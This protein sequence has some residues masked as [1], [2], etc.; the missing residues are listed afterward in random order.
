MSKTINEIGNRYGRLVVQQRAKNNSQGRAQWECLCDCGNIVYV[1]GVLLRNGTTKSC[2]CLQKERT[3]LACSSNLIG[4]TIGNFTVLDSVMGTKGG[5]RHKWKCRCNLCGN[6]E[7][8][9]ATSNLTQQ[10]S[11]GCCNESEGVRQIKTLLQQYNIPF[12]QEKRFS[13]LIYAESGRTA[14]FDFYVN[15]HYIIEYDG[16]Q[17]FIEGSGHYD[18]PTKFHYT[19]QHD[20]IKNAY[21]KQNNIP[22]IRIPYYEKNITIEM[23]LPNKSKYIL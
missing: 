13:N 14:R 19:Q 15:N 9:I 5:E 6:E 8:Y 11:C 1:Q 12:V 2:G 10:K 22:I 23:L 20:R 17:H 7:V 3:S 4:K 16:C 21:C 18:N